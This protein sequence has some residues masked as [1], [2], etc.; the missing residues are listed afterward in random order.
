MEPARP[1]LHGLWLLDLDR[2][3]VAAKRLAE[4]LDAA[5]TARRDAFVFARDGDRYAVAH[6]G[7]RVLL[8]RCLGVEP[9]ALEFERRPCAACGGPHGKP[10][11][12]GVG[13]GGGG[14]RGGGDGGARGGGD[15]GAR[16]LCFSLA[17][18]G[19]VALYAL[20][21]VEVGVDVEPR[22]PLEEL[23]GVA[24]SLHARERA[25]LAVLPAGARADALL[26]CWTRKEALLK[27]R[28]LGLTVPL[29][30]YYTGIGA[31]YG[32]PVPPPAQLEGWALA[33]V[34]LAGHHAAV[35][36]SG[37]LEA[38]PSVRRFVLPGGEP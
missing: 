1:V 2:H 11:L 30:G 25:A 37:A 31:A 17:H 10:A 16:E 27:A 6:V 4:V 20:A 35:G 38:V 23:D 3:A 29:A 14:A 34:P 19:G 7:L 15:G 18:A 33:D 32:Q 24:E 12:S 5:E 26:C 13:G 9:G 22:R 8:A 21:C 36:W 28:G